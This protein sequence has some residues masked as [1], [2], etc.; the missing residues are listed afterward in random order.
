MMR[1]DKEASRADLFL[2]AVL[3]AGGLAIT[4]VSLMQ[5]SERGKIH[6]AQA[7]QPTET[8]PSVPAGK[9]DGPAESKPGGTRPTTPA[10][11]PA[12]PDADAQKAGA[13]PALPPAPAEKMGDPIRK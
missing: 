11:E 6:F 1:N 2:S 4:G 13:K 8:Q 9:S 5:L 3:L 12:R 10:P 7:T